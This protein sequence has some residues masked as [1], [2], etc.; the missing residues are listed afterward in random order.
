MGWWM[1]DEANLHCRLKY[2]VSLRREMNTKGHNDS[3][4]VSSVSEAIET[5]LYYFLLF[6]WLRRSKGSHT[7]E[8][9][10]TEVN[11][12]TTTAVDHPLY[13]LLTWQLSP[14]LI[15]GDPSEWCPLH[16][17]ICVVNQQIKHVKCRQTDHGHEKCHHRIKSNFLLLLLLFL[18]LLRIDAPWMPA[19]HNNVGNPC[20]SGRWH[21]LNDKI[22]WNKMA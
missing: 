18:L 21:G 7:A 13:L 8:R 16:S 3:Q 10:N 5:E 12:F 14:L 15:A 17:L 22:D 1:A 20:M 19:W 6:I 2:Y 4:S 9:S 11:A